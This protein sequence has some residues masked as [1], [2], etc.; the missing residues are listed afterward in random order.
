M[1]ADSGSDVAMTYIFYDDILDT[2]KIDND[3]LTLEHVTNSFGKFNLAIHLGKV[4]NK[5]KRVL[6]EFQIL[7]NPSS[8]DKTKCPT[9]GHAVLCHQQC[10]SDDIAF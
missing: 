9:F 2:S 6:E 3:N 5:F 7:V 1:L 10:E 8:A 4:Q